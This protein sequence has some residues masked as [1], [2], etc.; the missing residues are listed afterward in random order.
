MKQYVNLPNGITSLRIVGAVLMFWVEPLTLP[1]YIIYSLCGLSDALDGWVARATG[2]SSD[3]GAQL[4]SVADLSFYIAMLIRILPK[5]VEL[6]PFWIWY[7]VAFLVALRILAYIIA[8]IRHRRFASL[9][10]YANKATGASMFAVPYLIITPLGM[11]YCMT[12]CAIAGFA[13][14]EELVMHSV[15]TDYNP[16]RKSLLF[17][18]K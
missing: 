11:A 12:V 9:H 16:N 3:F 4:D 6:L 10:T 14:V 18:V 1:F 5:L 13:A 2:T 7:V 15:Y 17:R 8:A